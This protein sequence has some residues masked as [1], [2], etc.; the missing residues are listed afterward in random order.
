MTI[1]NLTSEAKAILLELAATL[2]ELTLDDYTERIAL[3]GNAS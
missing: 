2:E 1:S 3:L